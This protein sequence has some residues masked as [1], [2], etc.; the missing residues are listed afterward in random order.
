MTNIKPALV[1]CGDEIVIN[2]HPVTVAY[3]EKDVNGFNTYVEDRGQ[4][5]YIF[6]PEEEQVT[7]IR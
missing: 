4:R 3:I 7:L 5:K 1:Q 2:Q 6:I